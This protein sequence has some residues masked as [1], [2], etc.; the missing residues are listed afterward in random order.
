[1]AAMNTPMTPSDLARLAFE[2]APEAWLVVDSSGRVQLANEAACARLEHSRDE[3]Q[4]MRLADFVLDAFAEDWAARW[5]SLA[6]EPKMVLQTKLRT[7]AG[8]TRLSE[9]QLVR[10]RLEGEDIG[11]VLL[12]DAVQEAATNDALLA[13]EERFRLVTLATEDAIYDFDI[14]TNSVWRSESFVKISGEPMSRF[15]DADWWRSRIHPDDQSTAFRALEEALASGATGW[16]SEYRLQRGTGE[17]ATLTD[18]GVIL[19]DEQGKP[20]RVIGAVTDVT[21]QR[22]I[23]ADARES[24]ARLEEA[25]DELK[26]KNLL[27]EGE[28]AQRMRREASLREQKEAIEL[29][30]APVVQLWDKVLALPVIGTVDRA[31]AS[32]IMEKLLAEIVRTGSVFAILDLTGMAHVD[33]DSAKHL[34]DIV[35]AANLL[36]SS[37]LLS[38]IAPSIARSMVEI[39]I[40]AAGV[41]TFGT[42]R[43]A[44]AHAIGSTRTGDVPWSAQRAA[45]GGSG[46]SSAR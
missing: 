22:R 17:Y 5:E 6:R 20:V 1:M 3:L 45:R 14:A 30:S 9:L 8:E 46:Q 44:L 4:G 35:R 10:P 27:L 24:L 12:R 42:L 32:Q 18:R 7:K 16:L 38:G 37:I 34:F 15:A 2:H 29:L 23:E 13:S 19:R 39:G 43:D 31:R 33:T 11:L 25:T 28:V 41:I 21:E 26:R 36:G 40:E